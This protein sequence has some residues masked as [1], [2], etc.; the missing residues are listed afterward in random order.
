MVLVVIFFVY[1]IISS[2][3]VVALCDLVYY[4]EAIHDLY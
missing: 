4:V 1:F 3:F 2:C